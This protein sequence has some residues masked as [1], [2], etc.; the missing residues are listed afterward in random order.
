MMEQINPSVSPAHKGGGLLGA[1]VGGAAGVLAGIGTTIATWNPGAGVAAGLAAGAGTTAALAGAGSTMGGLVGSKVD[2]SKASNQ[3]QTVP[4]DQSQAP[5]GLPI[6][7]MQAHPELQ[8]AT[9][10]DARSALPMAG[11]SQPE[12]Q[13]TSDLLNNAHSMLSQRLGIGGQA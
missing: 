2:P 8:L 4:L 3:S 5:S 11:L 7:S 12:Y 9:I 10:A 1:I 6:D 13:Q